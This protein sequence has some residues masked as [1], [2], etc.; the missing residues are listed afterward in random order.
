MEEPKPKKPI[1]GVSMFGGMDPM[2]A[3]RN[4]GKKD[5]EVKDKKVTPPPLKVKDSDEEDTTDKPEP[6][7]ME[8]P[9][10]EKTKPGKI[11][12]LWFLPLLQVS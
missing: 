2:A 3:L 7:P 6:P 12:W 9:K 8:A 11:V 1:G 10:T 5:N 4:K